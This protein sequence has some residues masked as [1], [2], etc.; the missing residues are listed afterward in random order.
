[1]GWKVV[2]NATQLF[3]YSH[4]THDRVLLNQHCIN[5][6]FTLRWSTSC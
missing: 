2:G 3:Y 4:L 1:M 6:L 5:H